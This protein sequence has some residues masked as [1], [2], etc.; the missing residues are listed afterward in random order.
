MTQKP[1]HAS[2]TTENLYSLTAETVAVAQRWGEAVN[3]QDV[4]GVM[5]LMSDDCVFDSS[6][7]EPDGTRYVGQAAIRAVW[8]QFFRASPHSVFEPEEISGAGERCIF[9]WV[10]RWLDAESKPQHCRGV[11]I[12]RVRNGKVSEKLVYYKRGSPR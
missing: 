9:R 4:D 5:A 10:H 1:Q 7:P 6:Y 12:L 11:D 3:R 8:E 2:S